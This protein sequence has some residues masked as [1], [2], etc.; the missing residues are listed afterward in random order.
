MAIDIRAQIAC[1][2]GPLISGSVSDDYVQGSGLIRCRGN[3]EISGVITPPVGTFVNIA[4]RR[5]GTTTY[6]ERSLR[7]LSFFADPFRRIT[8]VELGCKLTYLQELK[9]EI[10]WVGGDD[11][12]NTG[13]TEED[14]KKIT[15]PI[16]ASSVADYCKGRLGIAG[17]PGLTSRFTIERFDYSPGYVQVLSDLYQSEGY[18]AYLN[19]SEVLQWFSLDVAGGTG[20]VVTREQLIDVGSVGAGPV[21]W[22]AVTVLY[23]AYKSKFPEGQ[24]I[25]D[26]SDAAALEQNTD[27][28]PPRD[29]S[30]NILDASGNP[31]DPSGADPND[32]VDPAAPTDNIAASGGRQPTASWGLSRTSQESEVPIPY[33]VPGTSTQATAVFTNLQTSET[34]TTYREIRARNGEVVNVVNGRKTTKGSAASAELGEL[35]TASLSAGF[36]F[37]DTTILETTTESFVYDSDGNP[38]LEVTERRGTGAHVIG[39]VGLPMVFEGPSGTSLV[40]PN[41]G[42]SFLLERQ[43]VETIRLGAAVQ[44][45]TRVYGPWYRTL[46]GQQSIA[47]SRESFTSPAA[48]ADFVNAAAKGEYLLS[49]VVQS[50]TT[51]YRG[52]RGPSAVNLPAAKAAADSGDPDNDYRTSERVGIEAFSDPSGG[53][54]DPSGGAFPDPSGGFDPSGVLI[55]PSGVTAPAS[56]T[57][58]EL[59]YAD[60]DVFV[61]VGDT[62]QVQRG[63]AE[64]QARKIARI[65]RRL[66]EGSR[67]GMSIQAAAGVLPSA[68]FGPFIVKASGIS[69]M[70]RANGSGWTFDANG[71]VHSTDAL[72]YGGIGTDGSGGS[73]WFPVAPG[74]TT[75]PAAPA[76]VNGEMTV[77]STIPTRTERVNLEATTRA[78]MVVVS[79]GYPLQ[80]PIIEVSARVRVGAGLVELVALPVATLSIEALAPA[81]SVVVKPPTTSLA[82]QALVPAVTVNVPVPTAELNLEP[83]APVVTAVVDM[84]VPT[85]TLVL[86]PVAPAVGV[87]P[88]LPTIELM[89][90]GVPPAVIGA[91]VVMMPTVELVLEGVPPAVEAVAPGGNLGVGL[92]PIDP[93]F[94]FPD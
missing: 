7:V 21:P 75:L 13:L 62:Y 87:G 30:G 40:Q 58:V 34:I 69:A 71:I 84:K 81:V 5:G 83:V 27:P 37:N 15:L 89:L 59:P 16:F 2:L 22:D 53:F 72:F 3:V 66:A 10:R 1:S 61:K 56:S 26:L 90:E 19:R 52:Q 36:G 64:A 94:L 38:V 57:T 39:A 44:T 49:V 73:I 48:V 43:E 88:L 77:A 18:V 92:F 51:A 82:V 93:L 28:D 8:K 46:S 91:S 41:Y 11:P 23:S 9:E 65:Q 67:F 6:L 25:P 12:Q 78:A 45:T 33:T 42:G 79:Y 20:P 32:P 74:I 4:Y 54:Y 14:S 50:S 35:V 68:P 29:A 80:R 55:D 31:I 17:G 24:P 60:D 70:Y 86:E 76:V 47:G 85:T 63:N